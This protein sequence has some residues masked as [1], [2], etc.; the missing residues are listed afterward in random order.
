MKLSEVSPHN[1]DKCDV[2]RTG[3]ISGVLNTEMGEVKLCNEDLTKINDFDVKSDLDNA[4]LDSTLDTTLDDDDLDST[5]NTSTE[6][7]QL[8]GI[9]LGSYKDEEGNPL[10]VE[11]SNAL[12]AFSFVRYEPLQINLDL[13]VKL[14]LHYNV[15]RKILI[16]EVSLLGELDIEYT[17]RNFVVSESSFR[18]ALDVLDT[19]KLSPISYASLIARSIMNTIDPKYLRVIYAYLD[20]YGNTHS[21]IIET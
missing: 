14:T 2:C 11:D 19:F 18:Q 4:T 13:A 6:S 15:T 17:R 8:E 5:V 9:D 3:E 10:Y 12:L 1:D 20:I 21:V 7:K 16:E